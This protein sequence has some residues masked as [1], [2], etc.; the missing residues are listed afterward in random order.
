MYTKQTIQTKETLSAVLMNEPANQLS[1]GVGGVH[2]SSF[3]PAAH[4]TVK[5]ESGASKGKA[6][7]G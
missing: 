7:C 4:T 5:T 1:S 3:T 6:G 2:G